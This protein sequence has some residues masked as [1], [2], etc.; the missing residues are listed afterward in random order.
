MNPKAILIAVGILIV[1]MVLWYETKPTPAPVGDWQ[2]A[3][4]A[5]QVAAV[6]KTAI[7]PPKVEVYTAP[8]KKKLDLPAAVQQDTHAHVV[9]AT[10]VA[11]DDHPETVTTLLDD[12][13]GAETTLVRREPLPWIAAEQRGELRLDYGMKNGARK[14]GRLSFQEDLV[15]VKALHAGVN[16]NL[17]TDGQFFVGGGVAYKW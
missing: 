11:A 8:A 2:T 14:V 7:T 9:A 17:D 10:R 12:Q 16:A 1:A 15:E 3:K 4:H 13:T 5:P 6:P